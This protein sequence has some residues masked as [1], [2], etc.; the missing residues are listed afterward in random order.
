MTT[1][2]TSTATLGVSKDFVIPHMID[3]WFLRKDPAGL[4]GYLKAIRI[5][6]AKKQAIAL[7]KIFSQ[8]CKTER[9]EQ[10]W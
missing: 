1:A 10:F 3:F 9:L 7:K 5:P 4:V 2:N 6:G 8:S